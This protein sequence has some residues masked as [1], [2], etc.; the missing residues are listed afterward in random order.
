MSF[1]CTHDIES[2]IRVGFGGHELF[3]YVY[4]PADAQ[5]ESPRPYFHPVRTLGGRLITVVRPHD[6]VWHKGLAWSLPHVGHDN[7]WGGPTFA[8]DTGYVQRDNN[9]SMDH[10]RLNAIDVDDDHV[11]IQHELAWHTQAGKHIV[12][13]V[14]TMTTTVD[15]AST[16][17][18]RYDT[19]MT[20]TS[21]E[22]IMI[23]S[24]TTAG[25][26]NAGYGGLLWRGPRSF[27]GGTV[28]APGRAGGDELRGERAEWMGFTGSH[29]ETSDA[30][31]IVV[32]DDGANPAHP[33]RWF[34][35][36]EAF[37]AVCPAP[38][39][40]EEMPFDDGQT[41]HFSYAVVIADGAGDAERGESLAAKG[42]RT[43]KED[44]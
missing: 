1:T 25:R 13:E 32:V 12:D 8:R 14:R 27:T 23:G 6:H 19:A 21:G 20:N 40:S 42:R 17:V 16:W 33:P 7:F 10:E 28:L 22:R 44:R 37:A 31:T 18:L 34:V 9:G 36:S 4:R 26:E 39:F 11:R 30:S 38:F 29:D 15:D 43:P 5:R 35:R 41:L 2:S 3:T 24:P